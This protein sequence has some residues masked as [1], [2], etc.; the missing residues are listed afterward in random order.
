G[1]PMDPGSDAVR[2]GLRYVSGLREATG[3]AIAAARVDRP[4]ASVADL[5]A[6]TGLARD[7]LTTLASIGALAPLGLTRRAAL[8]RTARPDPGPLFAG[9]DAAASLSDPLQE[10]SATPHLS[11]SHPPPAPSSP[12]RETSAT[13]HLSRSH[14]PTDPSS[15]LRET[16][17]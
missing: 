15:P 7:E 9:I 10:T 2:L 13:P 8:W 1:S 4:F 6:R 5:I 12:L 14:P 11:R 3:L 16:S 17:A